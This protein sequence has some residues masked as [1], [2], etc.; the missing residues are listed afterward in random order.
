M[1]DPQTDGYTEK[2]QA[3]NILCLFP[4]KAGTLAFF[5]FLYSVWS[6]T[7]GYIS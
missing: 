1:F 7:F 3:C 5:S 4:D 2:G 6:L